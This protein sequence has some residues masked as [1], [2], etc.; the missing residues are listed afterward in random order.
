M[1]H[2]SNQNEYERVLSDGP[3]MV[4]G[5]YLTVHQWRPNFDPDLAQIEKAMRIGVPIRIDD[6]T[7]GVSPGSRGIR[8][9]CYH[10]T[11]N[12]DPILVTR[13]SGSKAYKGV[14]HKDFNGLLRSKQTASVTGPSHLGSKAQM[15][16]A[17]VI[18]DGS[19]P[20]WPDHVLRLEGK[21]L[22]ST[23][24]VPGTI[25]FH[26]NRVA[27]LANLVAPVSLSSRKSIIVAA[28]G[29]HQLVVGRAGVGFIEARK[30]SDAIHIFDPDG[31]DLL[32]FAEAS[33]DQMRVIMDCLNLFCSAFGQCVNV[34]KSSVWFSS[35]VDVDLQQNISEFSGI[36]VL[37]DIGSYLGVPVSW[38][39][40]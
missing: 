25:N 32:L 17:A 19:H 18:L 21:Q 5:H 11:P 15:P 9:G 39:G 6:I 22:T 1:A 10:P 34:A 24:K 8:F 28:V 16:F 33:L 37:K 13:S 36:R 30:V 7:L 38:K 23:Y 35:N 3:S 27:S 4:V 40:G 31:D 29:S 26:S 2:F 14:S 20:V 12:Q